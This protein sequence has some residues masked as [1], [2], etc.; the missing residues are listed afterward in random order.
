MEKDNIKQNLKNITAD[1]NIIP[2]IH[3]YCDRWCEKCTHTI[4]CSVFKI[5]QEL[6]LSNE[7][8]DVKNQ[9]FWT[10]LTELFQATVELI[11]EKMQ[12]LEIDPD[13]EIPSDDFI[14]KSISSEMV[15]IS[16]N[17]ALEIAKWLDQQRQVIL[18]RYNTLQNINTESA[19]LFA[20]TIEVIQHYFMIIAT[21]TYRASLVYDD[22]NDEN[23]DARG[24]A[25]VTIIVIDR[26][27]VAW[28][29]MLTY[30]PVMEDDILHFLKTLSQVKRMLLVAFPSAMEFV[31]PGF[32]E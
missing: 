8:L 3:N 30:F 1:K 12:E 20:D 23:D 10:S 29:A 4:H 17:Y 6:N 11:H 22:I 31:R 32:D 24:S 13:I 18:E 9:Q 16:R 2:S 27:I 26:S 5:E 19:L 15:I 25:K 21:K 14:S 28:S 7:E